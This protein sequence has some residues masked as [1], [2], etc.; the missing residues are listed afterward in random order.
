MQDDRVAV[1]QQLAPGV[2]ISLDLFLDIDGLFFIHGE[3]IVAAM[4]S[5]GY[6][7]LLASGSLVGWLTGHR[8]DFV[9]A[10]DLH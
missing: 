9:N 8:L 4:E 7:H 10:V 2:H 3:Y 1:F 6:Q 5:L